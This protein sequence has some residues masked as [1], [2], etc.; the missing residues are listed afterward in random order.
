MID[1]RELIMRLAA[2]GTRQFEQETEAAR[3][4]TGLLTAHGISY[5][6]QPFT[7]DLPWIKKAVLLV[8]GRP[9][10]VTAQFLPQEPCR[11]LP[12][13]AVWSNGWRSTPAAHHKAN[14]GNR[15][16]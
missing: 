4:I 2:L 16:R 12:D 8:D 14:V 9:V 11:G 10:G 5:Y 13:S 6:L 3:V 1:C 7:L 15:A